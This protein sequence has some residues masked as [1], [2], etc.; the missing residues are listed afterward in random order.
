M[1]ASLLWQWLTLWAFVRTV[2][3]FQTVLSSIESKRTSISV[4]RTSRF[5]PRHA[6]I[7]NDADLGLVDFKVKLPEAEAQVEAQVDKEAKFVITAASSD[8]AYSPDGKIAPTHWIY[9]LS[10]STGATASR[11]VHTLVSLCSII[12]LIDPC[13]HDADSCAFESILR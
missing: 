9:V 1:R 10:D 2:S 6:T 3:P 7:G 13:F 11:T 12:S 5:S 8:I 4:S